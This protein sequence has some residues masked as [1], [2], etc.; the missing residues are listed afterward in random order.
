MLPKDE[1]FCASYVAALYI[2]EVIKLSPSDKVYLIAMSGTKE[3]FANHG[4]SWI[5]PT[6][7][8]DNTLDPFDLASF[9]R[10]PDVKVVLF[11]GDPAINYT[12]LSKAFQYLQGS[13]GREGCTFLCINLDNTVPGKGGMY[14]G[15]GLFALVLS[16]ALGKRPL[17]IGKPERIMWDCIQAKSV[18]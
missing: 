8:E 11:G 5:G 18:S 7:P 13:D 14:L 3:E 15:A 16:T 2:S 12:K 10:D 17:L 4:I 6:S 1:I 9:E